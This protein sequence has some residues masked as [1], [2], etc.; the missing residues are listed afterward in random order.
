MARSSGK[1]P[2][3]CEVMP[4][5]LWC[6]GFARSTALALALAV[7][8]F[9]TTSGEASKK[10]R[11][12][13]H[14]EVAQA[15]AGISEDELYIFRISLAADGG[16]LGAYSFVDDEPRVFRISSWK[17]EPPFIH[18]TIEPTDQ[19]PL[20]AS[21]LNGEITGVRMHLRMS[22]KGWSRSLT[23]RREEELVGRWGRI[24]DAMARFKS[25]G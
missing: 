9:A 7:V 19:S 23:F 13:T 12:L 22:G 1:M 25:E 14:A 24:R 18:I 2:W 4:D 10:M 6:S 21:Q 20:V 11:Q 8:L 17:Y 3:L 15:W 5:Y 16:G